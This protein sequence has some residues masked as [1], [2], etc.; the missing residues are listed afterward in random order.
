MEKQ[1]NDTNENYVEEREAVRAEQR[2]GDEA[3]SVA[4]AAANAKAQTAADSVQQME[5]LA[6]GR[7]NLLG[8]RLDKMH[9]ELVREMTDRAGKVNT[10]ISSLQMAVCGISNTQAQ[11]A[12][13][14]AHSEGPGRGGYTRVKKEDKSKLDLTVFMGSDEKAKENFKPWRKDLDMALGEMWAGLDEVLQEVRE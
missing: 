10:E 1:F 4:A 3:T 7:L 12:P 8:S 9:A 6:D 5:T 13:V 11:A 14:Q 2:I